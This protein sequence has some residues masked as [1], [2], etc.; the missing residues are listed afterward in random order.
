MMQTGR[1]RPA[2]HT[3]PIKASKPGHGIE[4]FRP[5]EWNVC[6]S[7]FLSESTISEAAYVVDISPYH[8]HIDRSEISRDLLY[9]GP[10]LLVSL[11]QWMQGLGGQNTGN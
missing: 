10:P 11:L 9:T 3:P 4:D 6:N 2:D 5:K 7:V 1:S 8:R